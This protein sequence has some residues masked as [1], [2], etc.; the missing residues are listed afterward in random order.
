MGRCG[1][2]VQMLNTG[3]STERDPLEARLRP[4]LERMARAR[5]L[6]A[7]WR[8]RGLYPHPVW[9]PH[10]EI[11]S[12]EGEPLAHPIGCLPELLWLCRDTEDWVVPGAHGAA[13]KGCYRSGEQLA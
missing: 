2:I 5:R 4:A 11:Q 8:E 3:G 10:V 12:H 7:S 13:F 9:S 1:V 6:L